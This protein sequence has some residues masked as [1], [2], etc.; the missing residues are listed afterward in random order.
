MKLRLNGN[1]IKAIFNDGKDYDDTVDFN[2]ELP[3]PTPTEKQTWEYIWNIEKESI[4]IIYIDKIEE[5][6]K[7]PIN[8][9][10]TFAS[11]LALLKNAMADLIMG[12]V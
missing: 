5:T 12:G 9:M 8:E 7:A 3:I 2:G 10:S 1:T 6:Y 11:E 4:D